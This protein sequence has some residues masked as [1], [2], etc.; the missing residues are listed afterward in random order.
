[1]AHFFLACLSLLQSHSLYAGKS[2]LVYVVCI[3]ITL[4]INYC[5]IKMHVRLGK[6]FRFPL[7]IK[8][9]QKL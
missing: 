3:R 8:K 1:M 4:I 6:S 5:L 7:L 9:T 2:S